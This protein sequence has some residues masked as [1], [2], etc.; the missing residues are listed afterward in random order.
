MRCELCAKSVFGN[1]GITVLGLGAAHITCFELEKNTRHIFEGLDI[2]KL[3]DQALNELHDMVLAE[4]N[5]RSG[6]FADIA[7]ELF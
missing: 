7:V 4:K 6:N 1:E 5:H 3:D 2:A